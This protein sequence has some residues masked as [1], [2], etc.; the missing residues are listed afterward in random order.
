[1]SEYVDQRPIFALPGGLDLFVMNL[2]RDH[3]IEEIAHDGIVMNGIPNVSYYA[4]TVEGVKLLEKISHAKV[5]D[6]DDAD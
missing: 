6:G 3:I 4:A 5:I 1:M 2:L